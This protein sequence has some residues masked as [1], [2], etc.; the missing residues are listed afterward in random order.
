M[1]TLRDIRRHIRAIRNIEQITRAMQMVAAA[2]MRRAQARVV[3]GRPYAVAME[4]MVADVA[5]VGKE[6]RHPFLQGREE[7]PGVL[8]LVTSDR[9]LAGALNVNVTRAAHSHML[10]RFGPRYQAVV[11]GRKGL[12]FSHRMQLRVLDQRVGLPDQVGPEDVRP[13]VEAAVRAFLEDGAREV[14][15][16]Y[17]TFR[18]LLSQVPTVKTLVPVPPRPP[19][20]GP[21][22]EGDYIYE[23]D[24]RAVLE[25]LM[26]AYVEAEVLHAVR[27]LHASFYS[28]QMVAMRNASSSAGDVIRELSLTANKVRQAGI[29]R[30]LMEIIGG[31]EALQA[32]R[33]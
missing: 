11:L 2:K 10:R 25:R 26:P 30:E 27:E 24:A 32:A 16:A 1:A 7:G 13:A 9:G 28:A 21:V 5:K 23:P 33:R 17:P 29:T 6:Y 4:Q 14:V 19:E 12:E 31:A 20:E 3:A 18:N 8:I 15:L 22:T